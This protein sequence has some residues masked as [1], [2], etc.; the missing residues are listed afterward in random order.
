MNTKWLKKSLW[1]IV[2][3]LLLVQ[4]LPVFAA[5]T[6]G[7]ADVQ[8]SNW[9]YK[10]VIDAKK[11]GLIE[12]IGNGKYAPNSTITYAEYL[13]IISR[14]CD[15]GVEGRPNG[16]KWYDKYIDSARNIGALSKSEALDALAGIPR[17]DMIKFTCK[18]LGI[19]PYIGN[20]VIFNDVKSSD[21][22]YINA[23][24]NEYLTEG[25]SGHKV[26]KSL[27]F[28]WGNTSTRAELAT[29]ALRIKAYRDN[30][31]A[32]KAEKAKIRAAEEQKYQQQQSEYI[33]FHGYKIPKA[34]IGD[35]GLTGLEFYSPDT[36]GP[37]EIWCWA[38]WKD[39]ETFDLIQSILS[40]KL[41]KTVVKQA[42]DYGRTKKSGDNLK[43]EFKTSQGLTIH[44]SSATTDLNV[45][46]QVY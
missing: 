35:T 20:E 43:K 41:D 40:S 24:Y 15:S 42:V 16:N 18:A 11:A 30:P 21:A 10:D 32:F 34:P 38:S 7:F 17:Q 29:M 5:D 14:I 39:P 44:V 45:N 26:D 6:N 13:A 25:I 37:N 3:A 27:V 8:P 36:G 28:G 23:A 22:A 31:T 19:E 46:F 2:M 4:T 33:T 9:F 1:G 12:G